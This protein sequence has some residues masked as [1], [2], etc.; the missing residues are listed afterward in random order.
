MRKNVRARLARS[1]AIFMAAN[2]FAGP[3]VAGGAGTTAGNFLKI[4]TAAIPAALGSAYTGAGTVDSILYNPA[5]IGLVNYNSISFSHNEYI[6]GLKQEYFAGAMPFE[7]G[8][9]GAAFSTLSSDDFDAYDEHGSRIGQTSSSHMLFAL[10]YANSYPYFHEDKNTHDR[11]LLVP[12]WSK[13]P[14][15]ERY[16]PQTFR[17]AY[18]ATIRYIKER[19]DDASSSSMAADLGVIFVP[20]SHVQLGAA[21]QNIGG[22][23]NFDT[24]TYSLPLTYRFGIATDFLARKRVLILKALGDAV[25]ESDRDL[26]FN[27][28]LESNIRQMFQ[29]RAGYRTGQ[30]T[31][32]GL[33][34]GAGLCLDRFTEEGYFFRGIRLDYAYIHQGAFGAS[35]R[36]GF[37]ILFP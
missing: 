24:E 15:I 12:D 32:N 19:L 25:K 8:R 26:Y 35:H 9:I 11:M 16:R 31:G 3:A 10:N 18:G 27:F 4:P 2:L 37:Q 13:L 14:D 33:T 21:L 1:A 22:K 6:E 29:L 30:D 34:F 28:G 20:A 23:Q 17:I 5:G 7:W 36:L